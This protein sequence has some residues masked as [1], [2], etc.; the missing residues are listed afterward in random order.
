[1]TSLCRAGCAQ[2][3]GMRS[4]S[5]HRVLPVLPV[6]AVEFLPCPR[7]TA[8]TSWNHRS[9]WRMTSRHSTA[10]RCWLCVGMTSTQSAD[11]RR[12]QEPDEPWQVHRHRLAVMTDETGE[13]MTAGDV[14][15]GWQELQVSQHL[16]CTRLSR[17]SRHRTQPCVHRLAVQSPH[18]STCRHSTAQRLAPLPVC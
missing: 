3:R 12:R 2:C 11:G 14:C 10:V 1:M 6:L 8:M 7:H 15:R 17:Q 18:L 16:H 4:A 13:G 5:W 9:G